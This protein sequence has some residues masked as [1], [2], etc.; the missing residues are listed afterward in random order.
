MHTLFRVDSLGCQV[1]ATVVYV[2]NTN[3][4]SFAY[5]IFRMSY[6]PLHNLTTLFYTKEKLTLGTWILS[7][8]FEVPKRRTRK[9]SHRVKK[10]IFVDR[11]A[12]LFEVSARPL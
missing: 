3:C 5:A 9:H 12:E 2:R 1:D 11:L 8:Q 7:S 10:A 6:F 4:V